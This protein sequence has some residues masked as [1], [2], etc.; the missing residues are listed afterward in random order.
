MA[1]IPWNLQSP[2]GIPAMNGAGRSTNVAGGAT[3][4][5]MNHYYRVIGYDDKDSHL[6]VVDVVAPFS[7]IAEMMV[8]AQLHSNV[9][10]SALVDK[11]TRVDTRR[12]D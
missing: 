1:A 12:A 9:E 8:L 3:L 11:A 5:P 2:A 6:F 4:I 7:G 10:T